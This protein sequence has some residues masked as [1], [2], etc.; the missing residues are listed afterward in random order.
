VRGVS[1]LS[2]ADG[3]PGYAV[4]GVMTAGILLDDDVA[5][6]AIRGSSG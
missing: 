4:M 3:N 2:I 6:S 5:V 1:F